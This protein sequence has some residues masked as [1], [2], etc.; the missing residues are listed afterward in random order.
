MKIKGWIFFNL[1]RSNLAFVADEIELTQPLPWKLL[2]DSRRF[3]EFMQQF[4]P[5]PTKEGSLP[6]WKIEADIDD[7]HHWFNQRTQLAHR[8]EQ[9]DL[10]TLAM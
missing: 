1:D 5:V 4:K 8:D 7:L 9:D 3:G 6:G 2:L 10:G